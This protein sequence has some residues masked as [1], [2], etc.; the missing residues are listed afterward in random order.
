MSRIVW[1]NEEKLSVRNN[2]VKH[3]VTNPTLSNKQVLQQGQSILP[4]DRRVKVTDQR[5]FN[6]KDRIL[7][8]RAEAD[9]Q[10]A[11]QDEACKPLPEL[12]PTPV[13]MEHQR[14]SIGDLFEQLV[15]ALAQR[16]TDRV[17]ARLSEQTEALPRA[18]LDDAFG[19]PMD[20]LN[21][22]FDS[23]Y[24]EF[25]KAPIAPRRPSCLIIGLNGAQMESIKRRVPGVDF[26]F[27]T[28]EEAGSHYVSVKDHTI[29]MTKF[30]NHSVQGKYRK[31][32]NLHYCNG[33]VSELN[34]LLNGIFKEAA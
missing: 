27:L 29:L 21:D 18:T 28:A 11:L 19:H 34:T 10:R 13:P 1:T 32:P 4:Y 33:G 22:M 2:M 9:K 15:D 24:P 23:L 30:I 26:K 8:A 25:K 5:V 14:P 7:I 20:R 3:L 31:H 17:L 12:T 6:H 16:V